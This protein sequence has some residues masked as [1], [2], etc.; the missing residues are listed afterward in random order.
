MESA[1]PVSAGVVVINAGAG[2]HIV[3]STKP[4]RRRVFARKPGMA[5]GSE[6]LRLSSTVTYAHPG[7]PSPAGTAGTIV[8]DAAR[9]GP[10]SGTSTLDAVSPPLSPG[11]RSLPDPAGQLLAPARDKRQV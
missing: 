10:A 5:A 1:P 2:V 6:L 3:S 4:P 9:T 8:M 11:T 7:S